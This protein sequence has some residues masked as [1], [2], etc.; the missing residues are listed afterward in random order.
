MLYNIT[1]IW[2]IK[3]T[4]KLVV[5]GRER[6]VGRSNIGKGIKRYTLLCIK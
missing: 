5:T 3:N 4:K 6:E 1:Y 2:N